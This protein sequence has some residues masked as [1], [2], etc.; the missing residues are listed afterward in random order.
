MK[1]SFLTRVVFVSSLIFILENST[2]HSFALSATREKNA[3]VALP[4]RGDSV[5]ESKATETE[6]YE[7]IRSLFAQEKLDEVEGK[8]QFFLDA[9]PDS[10]FSAPIENILGIIYLKKK[11]ATQA[12]ESFKRALNSPHEPDS[13]HQ[14]V[15]YNLAAAQFEGNQLIDAEKTIQKINASSLDQLNQLKLLSL[16]ANLLDK[17]NQYREIITLIF[18]STLRYD[19]DDLNP[20]KKSLQK[21]TL[22]ALNQIKDKSTLEKF[23][24]DYEGSPLSDLLLFRLGTYHMSLNHQGQAESFFNLLIKQYPE[25]SLKEEIQSLLAQKKQDAQIDPNAIGVLLPLQGKFAKYGLRSLQGIQLALGLFDTQEPDSTLKLII[26][27]GGEDPESNREALNRL[28]FKHRVGSVIGPMLSKGA[29]QVFERA[30]EIGIPLISLSRKS[31]QNPEYVFSAGLTHS[32][33]AYEAA[34]HAITHLGFKKLAILSPN[35]KFGKEMTQA[36]WDAVESFG[37]EI[38]GYET[39][40]PTDTDFRTQV[41]KLSGLYYSG[42]RQAELNALSKEREAN[43]IKKRTR[44]TE[45]YFQLPPVVDFEAVFIP[46]EAK[47]SGQIIPTFAYRDVEN[48]KFIGTSAWNSTE[49]LTRIS[50]TGDHSYFVDVL[51]SQSPQNQVSSGFTQNYRKTFKQEATSIDAIAFDAALL[52]KAALTNKTFDSRKDI[53]QALKSTQRFSGSTGTISYEAG[54]FYREL[55]LISIQAGQLKE[56]SP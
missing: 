53:K 20:L 48:V 21:I 24:S 49:F 28:A 42:S 44:K 11:N 36:F 51:F 50:N 22:H 56:V 33:L 10:D 35:D 17:K 40:S 30:E 7:E 23:I 1:A 8:I 43:Q 54:K 37:G 13:F 19:D 6:Q 14:Y 5:F 46:D 31:P 26:E 16:K 55:K 18:S 45:K 29:E 15:L 32:L 9:H 25:S 3:P 27:D 34:R 39:Y 47:I 41:D 4:Q 12:V 52:L 38:V 2:I